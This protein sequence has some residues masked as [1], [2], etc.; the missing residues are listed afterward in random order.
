MLIPRLRQRERLLAAPL[1]CPLLIALFLRV[2]L[3]LLRLLLLL[4]CRLRR[5]GG[6]VRSGLLRGSIFPDAAHVAIAVEFAPALDNEVRGRYIPLHLCRGKQFYAGVPDDVPLVLA[7]GGDDISLRLGFHVRLFADVEGARGFDLAL[8]L[9]LD[10]ERLLER[11]VSFEI[12]VLREDRINLVLVHI[13]YVHFSHRLLRGVKWTCYG[14]AF[15]VREYPFG[16]YTV[17]AS[18]ALAVPGYVIHARQGCQ[19]SIAVM[20]AR[21]DFSSRVRMSRV[22]GL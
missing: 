16:E 10:H 15:G 3:L 20:I 4:A 8:E 17:P 18:P 2:L 21:R 19:P 13:F 22:Y 5:R 9:S 1:P 7:P 6:G 14:R 12:D 11:E